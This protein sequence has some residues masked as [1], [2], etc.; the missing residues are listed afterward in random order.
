MNIKLDESLI[1]QVYRP[2]N[3]PVG[4]LTTS[5]S[6]NLGF[7]LRGY[8]AGLSGPGFFTNCPFQSTFSIAFAQVVNCSHADAQQG[9]DL[10]G[11]LALMRKLQ[12]SN[13]V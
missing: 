4:G 7:N 5:D 12:G 2:A 10:L 3:R 11:V 13:P 6:G 1:N 8:F 9:T